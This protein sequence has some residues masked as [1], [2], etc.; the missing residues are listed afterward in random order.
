MIV[1]ISR[2]FAGWPCIFCSPLSDRIKG[3]I[4]VTDSLNPALSDALL[5]CDQDDDARFGNLFN[6]ESDDLLPLR[7]VPKQPLFRELARRL[8]I[9]SQNTASSTLLSNE[10]PANPLTPASTLNLT[11]E[12]RP[13]LPPLMT[14]NVCDWFEKAGNDGVLH[15][16]GM[17]KTVGTDERGLLPPSWTSLIEAANQI[18][19]AK[20]TVAARARS[21]HAHRGTNSFFG[22]S[23]GSAEI[24]NHDAE[25]L[26]L[27]L[28]EEAIWI[29][30][31]TFGGMEGQPVLEIRVES[32][33][34]ARWTAECIN[35]DRILK[36]VMFRGF[37]EPQME[38][39]HEVKWRHG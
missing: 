7:G 13:P 39:G 29:N 35:G 34:G 37:L 28:L 4:S 32:G 6:D 18:H 17:R 31:H 14:T 5:I 20:L 33:Y 26:V 8:E 25:Q 2:F 9:W 36:N 22:I 38:D 3:A 19:K 21:K 15:L 23:K 16:L 30:I 1:G 27:K 11:E 24:Q 10:V 12:E